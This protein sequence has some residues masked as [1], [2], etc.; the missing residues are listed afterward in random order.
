MPKP[1]TTEE[2]PRDDVLVQHHEQDAHVQ[3]PSMSPAL[4]RVGDIDPA[5]VHRVPTQESGNCSQRLFRAT[6][7]H[8]DP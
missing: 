6:S 2:W 5:A 8:R 4:T 7:L 3:Q 1:L